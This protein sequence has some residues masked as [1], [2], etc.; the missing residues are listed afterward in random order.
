MN[1]MM[2]MRMDLCA[3]MNMDMDMAMGMTQ[4]PGGQELPQSQ[5][6]ELET[7]GPAREASGQGICALDRA[8]QVQERVPAAAL[9]PQYI[10][11]LRKG[12]RQL[13][14]LTMTCGEA[15][16]VRQRL[17]REPVAVHCQSV[18]D[19]KVNVFF[20]A[21]ALVATARLIADRP[22][23]Q[24]SPEA[25]FMLGTLLG[26]A[27]EQ[28]CERYLRKCGEDAEQADAVARSMACDVSW[29]A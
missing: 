2:G 3:N 8:A 18:N 5:P 19:N 29:S 4:C 23:H 27:C 20:G 11:E 1:T 15:R 13:F 17:A 7:S 6:I 25:D 24:L 10:Y 21:P 12:V 28:Q 26:Y 22:L 14:L 16:Q 9:L